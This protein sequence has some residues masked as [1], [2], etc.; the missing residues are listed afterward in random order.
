MGPV[1]YSPRAVLRGVLI[2]GL[3]LSAFAQIPAAPDASI[4][5]GRKAP[6]FSLTVLPVPTENSVRSFQRFSRPHVTMLH[7]L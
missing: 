5:S 3:A 6:D 4:S 2:L 7:R 1:L